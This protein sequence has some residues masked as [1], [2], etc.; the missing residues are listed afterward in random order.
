[1]LQPGFEAMSGVPGR[2]H[3]VFEYPPLLLPA[4]DNWPNGL[5][6][7]VEPALLGISSLAR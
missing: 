1:M 5:T 3:R 7:T 2:K 4:L 6:A